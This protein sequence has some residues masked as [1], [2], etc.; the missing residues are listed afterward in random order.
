MPK[1]IT[2]VKF[3]GKIIGADYQGLYSTYTIFDGEKNIRVNRKYGERN[4]GIRNLS[5]DM[6]LE[7]GVTVKV[8]AKKTK[9]DGGKNEY[10]VYDDSK[11]YMKVSRAGKIYW[12]LS[13]MIKNPAVLLFITFSFVLLQIL[14]LYTLLIFIFGLIGLHGHIIQTSSELIAIFIGI[15]FGIYISILPELKGR[16]EQTIF[17]FGLLIIDAFF[18]MLGIYILVQLILGQSVSTI[19]YKEIIGVV[20]S[21]VYMIIWIFLLFWYLD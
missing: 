6:Y 14:G 2:E 19:L 21:L 3:T 11:Y 4:K 17:D 20:F 8:Y 7:N 1:D 13:T 9:F 12:L 5:D 10:S 16:G 15:A 18:G